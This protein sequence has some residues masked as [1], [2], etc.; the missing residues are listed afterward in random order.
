MMKDLVDGEAAEHGSGQ[1]WVL[2]DTEKERKKAAKSNL[3]VAV[4]SS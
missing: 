1:K 2:P 4:G 3:R